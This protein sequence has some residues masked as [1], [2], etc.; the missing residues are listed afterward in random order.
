MAI[1]AKKFKIRNSRIFGIVI[2]VMNLQNLGNSIVSTAI[3][4]IVVV[5][6][7]VLS[8]PKKGLPCWSDCG[9]ITRLSSIKIYPTVVTAKFSG[10]SWRSR[11]GY[12]ASRTDNM[13]WKVFRKSVRCACF[14]RQSLMALAPRFWK[15]ELIPTILRTIAKHS[16]IALGG[17]KNNPAAFACVSCSIH[18]SHIAH[19]TVLI[20]ETT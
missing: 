4:G 11:E 8:L 6:A 18:F 10:T 12:A 13:G 3:T 20:S 2:A 19:Y 14:N 15:S 16:I 5:L 17:R 7:G 9:G 1:R